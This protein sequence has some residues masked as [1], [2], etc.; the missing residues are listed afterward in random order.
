MSESLAAASAAALDLPGASVPEQ[1]PI[2]SSLAFAP[3]ITFA[4]H[5]RKDEWARL[6]ARFGANKVREGDPYYIDGDDMRPLADG[7]RLGWLCGTQYWVHKAPDGGLVAHSRSPKPEPFREHVEAVV[8]LYLPDK[9]VPCNV[10]FRTT[11]CG[12]AKAMS[13]AAALAATPD[14]GRQG[15]LYAAT[16]ALRQPFLRFYAD[17]SMS[18]PRN[19]KRTGLPYTT[20]MTMIV[21][22]G[23]AE[24]AQLK[25]LGE[26]AN[27]RNLFDMAMERY[28]SVVAG[29]AEKE[30]Q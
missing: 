12:A 20:L 11:K 14:W 16:M 21:P 9:V 24:W 29:V 30:V 5:A 2:V 18:A 1:V 8:L 15:S 27:Y 4:H 22:T 17:V 3:Y 13:E 26:D 28:N 25:S 19:S 7:M 23:P 10:T 6:N